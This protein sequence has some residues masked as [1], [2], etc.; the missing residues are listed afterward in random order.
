MKQEKLSDNKLNIGEIFSKVYQCTKKS[1]FRYLIFILLTNKLPSC[2]HD[3]ALNFVL[4]EK[5]IDESI[6]GIFAILVFPF[7]IATAFF[8]GYLLKK[9][10]SSELVSSFRGLLM[11]LVISYFGLLMIYTF[12]TGETIPFYYFCMLF[13]NN[14]LTAIGNNFFLISMGAYFNK[15]ADTTI[16]ASILSFL[17]AINSIGFSISRF[18]TFQAINL[19]TIKGEC[20]EINCPD[21]TTQCTKGMHGYYSLAAICFIF[22]VFYIFLLKYQVGKLESY[23]ISSWKLEKLKEN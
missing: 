5:G 3:N 2:F 16:A 7:D 21:C 8:V 19:L 13:V 14:L 11:K 18:C 6:F 10:E 22:S 1:N 17:N 4:N 15:I 20:T 12:P 9:N 23:P